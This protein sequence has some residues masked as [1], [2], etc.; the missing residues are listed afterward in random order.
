MRLAVLLW[1]TTQGIPAQAPSLSLENEIKAEF[2]ERFTY[3]IDWPAEAFDSDSAAFTVCIDGEG[4]LRPRLENLLAK[5]RIKDRPVLLRVL[6]SGESADGCHILYIAPS[7]RSLADHAV[8]KVWRAPVLTI[9]DSPGLTKRGVIINMFLE[10][11]NVR[12]AINIEAAKANGLAVSSKLLTMARPE[13]EN[14]TR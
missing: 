8:Q 5:G 11:P 10:G 6:D 12:F 3:Y 2:I 14:V 4:P 13:S 1:Y 7:E 9:G